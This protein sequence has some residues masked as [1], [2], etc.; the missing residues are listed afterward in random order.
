MSEQMMQMCHH[1]MMWL[2]SMGITPP[3][4]MQMMNMN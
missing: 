4:Q 2:H 1:M 3:M